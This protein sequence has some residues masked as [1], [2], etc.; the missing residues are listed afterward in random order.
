MHRP[1]RVRQPQLRFGLI[2]TQGLDWTLIRQRDKLQDMIT[3]SRENKLEVVGLSEL[4]NHVEEG[5]IEYL[6]LDEMRRIATAQVAIQVDTAKQ[7][8]WRRAGCVVHT[9]GGSNLAVKL[10]IEDG[11]EWATVAA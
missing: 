2:D 9:E 11:V 7:L 4:H 5:V 8:A 10:E 1:S 6:F 3:F